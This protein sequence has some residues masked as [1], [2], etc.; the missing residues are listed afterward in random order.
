MSE[1]C[2]RLHQ[3]FNGLE[4]HAYPFDSRA[5]PANGIYVMFED[6]E[7]AHGTNRIVRVGSHTGEGK[8]RSRLNEHFDVENKDRSIFRKNIGRA[9]LNRDRDPFL[10]QWDLDLTTRVAREQHA[11]QVDRVRQAEVERAVSAYIRGHL[12]FVAVEV[13]GED[14]RLYWESR[15][16]ATVSRCEECQPSAQWL[17]LHSPIGRIRGSGLWNVYR[18]YKWPVSEVELEEICRRWGGRVEW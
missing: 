4:V 13:A 17:G 9:L 8:L 14:E 12:R 15:I 7:L 1:A 3:L 18:L 6:G 2:L 5:I 11:G 16:I 10:D